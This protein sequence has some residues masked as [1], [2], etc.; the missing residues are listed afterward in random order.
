MK[1]QVHLCILGVILISSDVLAVVHYVSPTGGNVS[2]YT[3][4]SNAA[5]SVAAAIAQSSSGDIVN[6]TNGTYVLSN[7][8]SIYGGVTVTSVNGPAVT[9][10]DGNNATCV[11]YLN[12]SNAVLRGFTICNGYGVSLT[13]GGVTIEDGGTVEQCVIRNNRVWANTVPIGMG[14]G[15]YI[16]GQGV[17]RNCLIISNNASCSASLGVTV[18]GGG[19]E[20]TGSPNSPIS[21]PC[22]D[23]CTLVGNYA[24]TSGGGVRAEQSATVRNCIVY[25]NQIGRAHV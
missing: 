24:K 21:V 7:R 16:T 3:S 2:P 5:T 4:W 13:G 22:L 10:L 12:N 19:V 15:V 25:G 17:V 14:G 18:R 9:T 23:S 6:V 8:I 11:A 20:I 1:R